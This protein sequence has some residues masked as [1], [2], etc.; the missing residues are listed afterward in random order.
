M[1]SWFV[2]GISILVKVEETSKMKTLYACFQKGI[3]LG[4][5]SVKTKNGTDQKVTPHNSV[6]ICPDF[7][8]KKYIN[9]DC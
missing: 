2:Y 3:V 9:V 4:G 6:S 8:K 1:I 5:L 7:C